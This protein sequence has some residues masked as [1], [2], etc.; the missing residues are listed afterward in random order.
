MASGDATPRD[1]FAVQLPADL[2]SGR[3]AR[4]LLGDLLT[5]SGTPDRVVRDAQLVLHELVVNGVRHGRGD[6][7]GEIGVHCAVDSR[8][9]E[10]TVHDAGDLGEVALRPPTEDLEFGRGLAIVDA[11]CESW[12]VDRTRGTRV[13]A[14]IA[15]GPDQ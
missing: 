8:H 4:D 7:R 10:L 15:L 1:A 6:E 12:V 13:S 2:E 11:L 14:R 5:R 9:I 3:V